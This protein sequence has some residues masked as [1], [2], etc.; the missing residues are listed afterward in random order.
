MDLFQNPFYILNA[1]PQDNRRRIMELADSR[2]LLHDPEE[3]REAAA[4]LTHPRRRLAA[5]MAWM[6]GVLPK[7]VNYVLI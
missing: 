4:T 1:T 5:E 6:L 7:H 2:S 3:C